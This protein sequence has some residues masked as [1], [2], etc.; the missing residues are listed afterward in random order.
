MRSRPGIVLDL[1]AAAAQVVFV[2]V[3]RHGYRSVPADG[4][5]LVNL[6]VSLVGGMVVALV[7]GQGDGLAA[8]RSLD[9]WPCCC[10]PASWRPGCRRSCS[11][12][13][14]RCIGGT[15]TGILMLLEPV[16]GVVLAALWLGEG[17]GPRPGGGRRARA[18]GVL[19]LQVRSD[20]GH[21]VV[22]RAGRPWSGRPALVPV[23]ARVP[24]LAVIAYSTSP[25]SSPG[26]ARPLPEEQAGRSASPASP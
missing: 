26:S 5:T 3:S 15:R 12:T 7:I 4:A 11:S 18:A 10:S 14:I 21:A 22:D 6:G 16:V 25:S 8:P 24:F 9:P 2:T 20:P 19:V 1:A 17:A 13:A 23:A